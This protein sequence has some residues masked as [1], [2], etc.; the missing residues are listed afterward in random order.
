MDSMEYEQILDDLARAIDAERCVLFLG[1]ACSETAELR[2]ELGLTM[3]EVPTRRVMVCKLAEEMNDEELLDRVERICG[4]CPDCDRCLLPEAASRYEDIHGREE[5]K[6][7]VYNLLKDGKP[8]GFHRQLWNL[9]FAAIYTINYD[10]LVDKSLNG[11][12]FGVVTNDDVFAT[13]SRPIDKS[14][15]PLYKLHG[16]INANDVVITVDDQLRL[17]LFRDKSVLWNQLSW[18]LRSKVF[19]FVGYALGDTDVLETIYSL[20]S[21]G[22]PPPQSYAVIEQ[23]MPFNAQRL[24]Q[25]YR[26]RPVH[27][28]VD[29]FFGALVER[30]RCLML[31]RS[32]ISCTTPLE[33]RYPSI[34]KSFTQVVDSQ[35]YSGLCLYGRVEE[36]RKKALLDGE[37]SVI[38]TEMCEEC[39]R[40]QARGEKIMCV[41]LSFVQLGT[42]IYIDPWRF[43]RLLE[44][45]ARQLDIERAKVGL[46]HLD[47]L[48]SLENDSKHLW[49]PEADS[50][51]YGHWR[52]VLGGDDLAAEAVENPTTEQQK[53]N[54]DI[55]E[56]YLTGQAS[57]WFSWNLELA[58]GRHRLIVFITDFHLIEADKIWFK[59]VSQNFLNELC[60]HNVGLIITRRSPRVLSVDR[61]FAAYTLERFTQFDLAE[62]L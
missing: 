16:S 58:L 14:N 59:R 10:E 29:Q 15:I 9:P 13:V 20:Y 60:N 56:R 30:Y 26:I 61:T 43:V 52:R 3:A 39:L 55:L 21:S 8:R 2:K 41:S 46:P 49:R 4:D 12:E 34:W 42:E 31:Q 33:Y 27:Q 24:L 48:N 6:R 36:Q 17:K 23:P 62:P 22:H 57:D 51:I 25:K 37:L 11:A 44:D 5:L 32:Q 7:F 19:L 45:V 53:M 40:R 38:P 35:N 28:N 18:D 47:M 54:R 50:R 1:P